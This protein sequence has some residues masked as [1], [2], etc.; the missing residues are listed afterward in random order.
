MITYN[1]ESFITQAI[2][3]VLMQKTKFPIELVIGEDCSTD[4]TRE[5]CKAFKIKCPD[6][7]KLRLPIK[8][9]GVMPNFIEN[10]QACVGKYIAI[11]EGDDYWTDTHKLQKQV[12]FL[13]ANKDFA[14]CHHNMQVI[15]EDKTKEP[16]FSNSPETKEVSTIE[17]LAR[18]NYIFT[19]SCIFRNGLIKELPDW[20]YKS[21]VGD[22]VL[23]M[24]NAQHGKIKY[25]P[26]IMGVYR[27][28]K[29]GFWESKNKIY[30][31]E[32]WIKLIDLM[33]RYFDQKINKILLDQQSYYCIFLMK[34]FKNN[35][36]KCKY[37]SYKI[38]ENNPFFINDLQNKLDQS[39]QTIN[40]I[41]NSWSYK[42]GKKIINP[43][44]FLKNKFHFHKRFLS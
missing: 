22:Y 4:R 15:Y 29:D 28:L 33:K 44:R 36:E 9:M 40:E 43:V 27:V 7:I 32:H 17:D 8:N 18:R 5:I 14:I 25:I 26:D 31:T 6:I 2:E 37:Y 24:L 38:I 30:Q 34:H 42:T 21:P 3:G 1:H 35:I 16:Y 10:L 13:E 11:C 39:E 20:F 41:I 12:D 23:H 19:A